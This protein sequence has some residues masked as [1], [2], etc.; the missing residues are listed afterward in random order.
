MPLDKTIIFRYSYIYVAVKGGVAQLRTAC[1]LT[2]AI[3]MVLLVNTIHPPSWAA[4]LDSSKAMADFQFFTLPTP[5]GE[6]KL[7]DL[8]GRSIS[9]SDL[10]G[11]VVLLNF[12][13]KNCPYCER[14]KIYL[15]KMVK[16]VNSPNLKVVC[17]NLWDSRS[18]IRNLVGQDQ[19]DLL[20]AARPDDDQSVI[21]NEISGKIMGYYVVN[22]SGEAIYEI[23]GFPSTYIIDKEGKVVASHVGMAKW[24]S[25]PVQR[26]ITV[27]VNHSSNLG[28]SDYELPH[29]IDSLLS[30]SVRLDAGE[31][32]SGDRA[33]VI[34][35]H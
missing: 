7:L 25:S 30:R 5:A 9:L 31:V 15:R 27:L 16:L 14:E 18:S 29:W 21:K 23:K 2:F 33:G 28:N 1:K 6:L 19:S 32:I 17:A 13:R 22:G 10:K 34:K 8:N 35:D 24:S 20:F 3:L 12:W 11:R 4:P 26:F